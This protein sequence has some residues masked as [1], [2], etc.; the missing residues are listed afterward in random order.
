[1]AILLAGASGRSW[2]LARLNARGSASPGA[3]RAAET[4]SERRCLCGPT[5]YDRVV[6]SSGSPVTTCGSGD[7]RRQ[8]WLRDAGPQG[9]G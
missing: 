9:L 5:L 7:N 8:R 4:R 2:S 3:L 6:N 1:M